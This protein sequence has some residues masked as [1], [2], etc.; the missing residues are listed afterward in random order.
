ML[1]DVARKAAGV[2]GRMLNLAALRQAE[3]QQL[4]ETL[5][6][7]AVR[8]KLQNARAFRGSCASPR[9]GGP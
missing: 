5:R 1:T 8:E 9:G 2:H 3:Q 6:E 7:K 4:R